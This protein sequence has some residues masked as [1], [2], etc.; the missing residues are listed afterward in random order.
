MVIDART[1]FE[2]S[3]LEKEYT[4][5]YGREFVK[6]LKGAYWW[7]REDMRKQPPAEKIVRRRRRENHKYG[8]C[9][10]VFYAD[11][12]NENLYSQTIDERGGK[13]IFNYGHSPCLGTDTDHNIRYLLSGMF[14][15][16]KGKTRYW[17]DTL[18]GEG[19]RFW[20][21]KA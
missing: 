15:Y 2:P 16:D 13:T 5:L 7:M 14:F 18:L 11:F 8:D 21:I 12:P 1:A 10:T 20:T 9:I 19:E 17:L 6:D 4:A 3:A